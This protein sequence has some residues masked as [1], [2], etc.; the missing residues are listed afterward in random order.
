MPL[1]VRGV[2]EHGKSRVARSITKYATNSLPI[3]LRAMRDIQ[4][5]K[6]FGM[7]AGTFFIPGL[8]AG[9]VCHDVVSDQNQQMGASTS[10]AR[11]RA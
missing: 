5:L 10:P 6:F 11:S 9:P 2:R 4:P 7:I 1:S 8:L 3:I